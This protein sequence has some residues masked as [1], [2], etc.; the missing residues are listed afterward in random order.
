ML[1]STKGARLWGNPREGGGGGV[2]G[3]GEEKYQGRERGG[4]SSSRESQYMY[5]KLL[6]APFLTLLFFF[7]MPVPASWRVFA[8][9]FPVPVTWLLMRPPPVTWMFPLRA[10][11]P[12]CIAEPVPGRARPVVRVI[13]HC[14]RKDRKPG[15]KRST[16]T[17]ERQEIRNRKREK[18]NMSDFAR[19]NIF[20]DWQARLDLSWIYGPLPQHACESK[21]KRILSNK[22]FLSRSNFRY[23]VSSWISKRANRPTHNIIYYKYGTTS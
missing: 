12:W 17:E 10:T 16:K 11:L 23:H 15:V 8:V 18:E 7:C 13:P 14:R 22:N 3:L 4:Y 5:M 2:A 1:V 9:R 21:T 20:L 6:N 19:K